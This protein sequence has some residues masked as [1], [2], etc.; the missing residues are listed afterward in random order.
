MKPKDCSSSMGLRV[1]VT[2]WTL[3][4]MAVIIVALRLYSQWQ[5]VRNF[6][7]PDV[8]IILSIVRIITFRTLHC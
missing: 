7:S 8:F 4:A 6:R 3:A 2:I 1:L 5:V